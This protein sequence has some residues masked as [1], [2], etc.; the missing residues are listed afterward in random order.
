MNSSDS[1]VGAIPAPPGVTPNFTNPESRAWEIILAA[2]L[3]AAIAIAI[4]LARAYTSFFII[5]RWYLDDGKAYPRNGF[6]RSVMLTFARFHSYR[7]R[8]SQV[9]RILGVVFD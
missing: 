2:F 6:S 8:K 5:K 7:T 3:S 9:K 4:Y 1:G